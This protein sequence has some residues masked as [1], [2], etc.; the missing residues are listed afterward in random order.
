VRAR[1]VLTQ[2]DRWTQLATSA[3]VRIRPAAGTCSYRPYVRPMIS[4]WI[5]FVPPKIVVTSAL[6]T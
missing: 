6:R 5:S 4:R 3:G 1:V 2:S